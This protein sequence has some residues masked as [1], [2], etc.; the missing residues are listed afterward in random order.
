MYIYWKLYYSNVDYIRDIDIK[1]IEDI[2]Y[3]FW[4]LKLS[5]NFDFLIGTINIFYD[6][7]LCEW[8]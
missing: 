2:R 7:G 3:T 8:N 5:L 6:I 1:S 4:G